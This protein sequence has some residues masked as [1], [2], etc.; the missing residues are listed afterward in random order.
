MAMQS[1]PRPPKQRL[2]T[3]RL[4]A[5]ILSVSLVMAG[6][7]LGVLLR[8]SEL[9]GTLG[10][11]LTSGTMAFTTMVFFQVFN[12]LNVHADENTVF[13]RYALSNVWIWIASVVIIVL[14]VL[15]VHVG[16][17]QRFFTTSALTPMQWLLS[18]AVGSSVLWLE[19]LRKLV[20]QLRR[21][22]ESERLRA[23]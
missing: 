13:S 16:F 9:T 3:G 21:R 17:L 1:P 20:A 23:G 19:E 18:I 4:T 5:R 7:T 10:D 15:A 14:Q 2:L 12:L 11:S 6:G 22:G 8:G